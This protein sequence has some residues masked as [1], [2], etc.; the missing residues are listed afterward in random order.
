VSSGVHVCIRYVLS[1][2]LHCTCLF[3]LICL[4]GIRN[5]VIVIVLSEDNSTSND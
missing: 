5:T 1:G 3:S 2:I 4:T